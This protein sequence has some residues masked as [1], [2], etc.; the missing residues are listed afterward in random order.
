MR[1]HWK[2]IR[3]TALLVALSAL[4]AAATAQVPA[5]LSFQGRLLLNTGVPVT[6]N[7]SVT[8]RIIRGGS[9]TAVPTTGTLLYSETA[10][11]TPDATGIFIHGI[12]SGTPTF[13]SLT[14]GLFATTEPI[15]IEMQVGGNPLIP[16]TRV[17][18]TGYSVFALQALDAN[19]LGGNPPEDF[20]ITGDVSFD[21][22]SGEATDAQVSDTLTVGPA[23]SVAD[24]ALSPNVSLL[25]PSIDI[26][27]ETTGTLPAARVG[28]G[29]T[30]AQVN[31]TLTLGSASTV[32]IG[33]LNIASEAQ[34]DVL[35]RDAAGWTRLGP[36]SVGQVLQTQGAGANPEWA[37]VSA[38]GTF[39]T[40][41]ND[42]GPET[43]NSVWTITGDWVNTTVP[44]ADSEV[45]DNIT[46]T[47]ITQITNRAVADTTGDL[48]P[49]RLTGDTVDNDLVDAA[50]V[51]AGLTDAQVSDT[52]TV[53]AGG[54]VA[55]GALSAN[56]SLLGPSVD[57][58]SEVTGT[59]PAGSVGNGLT[60]AQINNTLTLGSASTVDIGALNIA[61]EAQGDI[62]YRDAAGWTRLAPGTSGQFLQTQGA[63]ANPQWA[64]SSASFTDV[65]TDYGAET[66]TSVW[67]ISGNWVNTANPW[68]DN[69]VADALTVSAGGSV[70][71]AA[72][73]NGLTDAQVNDDITLTNITQ[74]TNRAVADTTGDLDP[75]RLSGDTTDNDLV[76]AGLIAAGL[77]DAQVSDTL[78][79]GAAGS[80]DDAA[81]SA[82][83]A[84]LN[85]AETIAANWVN[86]ANPWADNEI[87]DDITVASSND[88][89]APGGFKMPFSFSQ[90]DV[91]VSQTAIGLNVLS[92][93][94]S[95]TFPM[96]YSG[97]VVGIAVTTNDPRT[98]GTLTVEA[99]VN[100]TGTGLT[101][102]LD[103]T[104]TTTDVTTQAKD[105]DAF[106]A[107]NLLG[108]IITT[109]AGWAPTTADI[110]VTVYVEQ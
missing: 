55:D 9:A 78:T 61:S 76:D 42:Y 37:T 64:T 49:D 110:V 81:L 109:D 11:V 74:I 35:I 54:S 73:G 8:F 18:T 62:L 85:A 75:D 97:S 108:A 51:G 98:A 88:I 80:V 1:A 68:S 32:D 39:T 100:G 43:V 79:I 65:D 91:T 10:N 36:G 69:E 38:G 82:N 101:A 23:G 14:P 93:G 103:G 7:T 106:A 46:L 96:G 26:V 48:D 58:A 29:L 13:G 6:T 57:L 87:A 31:N 72:V 50:L 52:L 47:N 92:N 34:G 44:W 21:Q 99:T 24:G 84:H 107:G 16:R 83:V 59:L 3:F 22:I 89:S 30:D 2:H 12:G 20:L 105:A 56:V 77:T 41:D 33:A 67:T 15:F 19:T 102:A 4:A 71:A 40:V 27:T 86:T 60:D 5:I 45:A 90:T 28:N 94:N 25:G 104:N 70:A 17:T 66:V 53:G 63:A 95:F